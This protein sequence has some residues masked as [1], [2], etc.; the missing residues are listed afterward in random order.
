LGVGDP[1]YQNQGHVS[2]KVEKPSGFQRRLERDLSDAFGATLYD[3]PETREEVLTA[4]KTIGSGTVILLGPNATE[5]AFKA[6][7]LADFKIVHIAAHGF[8]DTQFPE[9]SGLV[10]GV[11]P[12]S[13]DDGLL[14][15]R[16]II[17]LHFNAD[18]VTL[19][20]AILVLGRSKGKRA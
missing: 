14:Q 16:E 19:L 3:L 17:R 6:E 18:L 4:S 13:H 12:S 8:V 11:D 2:A 5:T 7:P 20:P 15:V 1:P 10:L 9:R